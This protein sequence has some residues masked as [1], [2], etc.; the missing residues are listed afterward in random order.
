MT[1]ELLWTKIALIIWILAYITARV[2]IIALTPNSNRILPIVTVI[3]SVVGIGIIL[4]D[5]GQ[6]LGDE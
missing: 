5:I 6:N 3:A 4:I 1:N 2:D